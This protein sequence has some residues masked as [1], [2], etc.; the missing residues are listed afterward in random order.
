MASNRHF[1]P[2]LLAINGCADPAADGCVQKPQAAQF[3]RAAAGCV[4]R[5]CARYFSLEL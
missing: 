1:R 2:E 4:Q 5:C 3:K